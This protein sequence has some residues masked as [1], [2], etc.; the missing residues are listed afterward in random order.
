M[1]I[2]KDAGPFK[3]NE[4]DLLL[5]CVTYNGLAMSSTMHQLLRANSVVFTLATDKRMSIL[6]MLCKTF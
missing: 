3:L 6:D 1:Y 2:K 5:F 4:V